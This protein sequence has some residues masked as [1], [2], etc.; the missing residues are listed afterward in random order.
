[1]YA[2]A[3]YSPNVK[4]KH[5]YG[6]CPVFII[7]TDIGLDD[8]RCGES[9]GLLVLIH[10]KYRNDLLLESH[11]LIHSRQHYR[12]FFLGWVQMLFNDDVLA[13]WE[14]EAYAIE[15]SSYTQIPF[16][17]KMIKEN[18][19]V[20]TDINLIEEYLF[21]YWDKCTRHENCY[22]HIQSKDV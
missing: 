18:Y 15:I 14:S 20:D 11:E 19:E 7:Y 12:T 10:P 22:S 16:Y 17:A 2:V 21:K 13:E 8:D 6:V 3:L 1:M 4:V 5:I 9:R